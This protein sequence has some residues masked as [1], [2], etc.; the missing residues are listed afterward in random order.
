MTFDDLLGM[1]D[2]AKLSWE[3]EQNGKKNT[4]TK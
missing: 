4:T 3:Q 1:T 2:S